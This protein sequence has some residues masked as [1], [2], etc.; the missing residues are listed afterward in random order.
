TREFYIINKQLTDE[1]LIERVATAY[2]EVYQTQLQL[3]TIET[4]LYSTTK[5]RDVIAGLVSAGLGKQIDLDR[6]NVQINNLI[7]NRQIVVNALELKENALKFAIGMP[8][9]KD[10]TLPDNTFEV[11]ANIALE[12]ANID[13][14][15]EVLLTKKQIELLELNKKSKVADLYPRLSLGADFGWSGFG[16]GYP[17]GGD[18]FWPKTSSIGLN[19]SIPIFTGGSTRARIKQ[20]DIQIRQAQVTLED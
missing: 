15:T 6:T 5:I 20:A 10:I 9:D 17:I 13:N 3:Q 4:N 2:Y 12:E 18:F 14:R 7:A 16:K 11:D 19:L 1:Q 8:M